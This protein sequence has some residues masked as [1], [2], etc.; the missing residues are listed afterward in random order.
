MTF[1]EE[2]YDVLRYFGNRQTGSKNR[3][4]VASKCPC[5]S[6]SLASERVPHDDTGSN[7]RARQQSEPLNAKIPNLVENMS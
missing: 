6:G 4:K 2:F 5:V 3:E 1:E 7:E